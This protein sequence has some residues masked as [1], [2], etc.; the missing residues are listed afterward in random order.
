MDPIAVL[1]RLA[2]L[3]VERERRALAV[4]DAP[5][6]ALR[7]RIADWHAEAERERRTAVDLASAR[8]LGAYLEASRRR[9]GAAESELARLEQAR[10]QQ[11]ARLLEQ[12]R[13]LK[14]LELLRQRHEQ[15]RRTEAARREQ[16]AI[17]ELALLGAARRMPS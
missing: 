6:E 2:G 17:D 5:I 9:L 16:R 3:A 7:R 13:E 4:L 1:V 15:R 12:R 8:L 10:A 14:R 11:A